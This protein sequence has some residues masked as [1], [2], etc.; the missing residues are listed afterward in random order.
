MGANSSNSGGPF[1]IL[2]T[3]KV[4]TSTSLARRCGHI[5]RSQPVEN[6]DPDAG[7][8]VVLAGSSDPAADA[9]RILDSLDKPPRKNAVLALEVFMGASPEWWQNGDLDAY[10]KTAMAWLDQTYGPGRTAHVCVHLDEASPHLAAVIIPWVDTP[11]Q[12]RG[13]KPKDEQKD[14]PKPCRRL[15]C[16]GLVGTDRATMRRLQSSFATAMAPLG[17]KRGIEGS[18]AVHTETA[19]WKGQQKAAAL[20][21]VEHEARASEAAKFIRLAAEAA[22]TDRKAAESERHA[23]KLDHAATKADRQAA[24][25]E[26]RRAEAWSAGF[27]AVA[28]GELVEVA[29]DQAGTRRPVF[30]PAVPTD[31]RQEIVGQVSPVWELLADWL[32]A[33]GERIRAVLAKAEH[34]ASAVIRAADRFSRQAGERARLDIAA[35]RQVATRVSTRGRVTPS[36]DH[37][38]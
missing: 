36:L 27:A 1:A 11:V 28:A 17:L 2:R 25:G 4:K 21:A 32:I 18:R 24:I 37:E 16:A 15:D 8:I 38:L 31:R 7:G 13:R 26:Q 10:G 33:L 30:G 20:A 19:Q 12:K 29:T 5:A 9:Q 3:Q 23:A 34:E 22:N 35:S 6:A 14:E